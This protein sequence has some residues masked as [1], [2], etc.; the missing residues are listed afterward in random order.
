MPFRPSFSC[1]WC[2]RSWTVRNPS[3]L[4]GWAHLC[5]DCVGRA[6]DNSF[7]RFRL[8]AALQERSKGVSPAMATAPSQ[9]RAAANGNAAPATSAEAGP[10]NPANAANPA[11]SANPAN[12]ANA[13]N[14]VTGTPTSPPA[15]AAT[16]VATALAPDL[17]DEMV[18]YYAARAPEYDD[19]YLRR[20]RYRRG[21]IH[22]MAWQVDLDEAT[23]WLDGQSVSGRIVELAAGTGWWSPLLA[24]K[25][26]LWAFDASQEPLDIARERLVAHGLR[27]HL[28]LRDAWAEPD[29]PADALFAGFWLSHVPRERLDAFL[30]LARRWLKPGGELL[31][32]DSR[33]DP[34]SGAVDQGPPDGADVARRRLSD[35]REFRVVKVFH[36][37]HDLEAAL[38]RAGFRDPLVETTSRFFLLGRA[39]AA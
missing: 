29:A 22:D 20:G 24:Q 2:G 6:G 25:G 11:N 23:R 4:E 18:G 27:A 14:T 32:I 35:G 37:P 3:D 26:E 30:A 13:A 7:L 5:P 8:K 10:A 33:P 31:F 36:E 38:R 15:P 39:I 21:P 17:R 34:Q 9:R 12:P 1:L 16:P 19:W 28:H